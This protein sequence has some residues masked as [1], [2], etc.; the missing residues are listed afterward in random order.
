MPYI[1]EIPGWP[2]FL[3]DGDALANSLA[4]V[5]HRQG[6][7]LGRMESLGFDLRAE[8]SLKVLTSDVVKSSAIE[9]ERLD[10]EEVRSSI[11]RRLGL[12]VAG[13]AKAGREVE[14]V[15]EMM[16]DA[17]QR[18]DQPLTEE[19][20]FGWHGALFPTGRAG[21]RRITVGA[22]RP[23]EAGPMRVVS[24]PIG[25][26]RVHFEAPGADRL[27]SEMGAFLGWFNGSDTVDP[28]LRAGVAHFW[29]VTIHPF[30]DGNGRIA[31]AIADMA[32][33]RADGT[34]ERFYSMSS[35]IEAERK[36]YYL[37]L[38]SGQ[39]GGLDITPW[40]GWFLGCL[41]RA[42][43]AAGATLGA[44]LVKARLWRRINE[45]PV[46]E[47]QR[48]VINRML[49]GFQGFLTTSKYAK[50]AKCSTDTALRDIRELLERDIIV[51]NPGGG[52]ST[53]YRLADPV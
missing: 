24:G 51:Q 9:G 28:V 53:S 39:R 10:P 5:R 42:I 14:G 12:D 46:N 15:V 26:E 33:A 4:G 38:E 44:V 34:G 32:L 47:R 21:M 49:D 25:R 18:F 3:W 23:S 40:L 41:D 29:F 52:R 31:R 50:L 17:T 27:G 45:R 11:A 19:R 30:E 36:E 22:W 16:L 37:R 6:L 2:E 48:L 1:H 8:A 35:Q 13:L 20:L 43:E 7:L